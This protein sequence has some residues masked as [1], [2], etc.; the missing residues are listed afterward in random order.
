M[1]RYGRYICGILTTVALLSASIRWSQVAWAAEDSGAVDIRQEESGGNSEAADGQQ[2]S[3]SDNAE[4]ADGQQGE[5]GGIPEDADGQQGDDA[6]IP[7]GAD[8][9]QKDNSGDAD[10][11][12]EDNPDDSGSADGQQED[13]PDDSGSVDG[14]Q[15]GNSRISGDV[16][17]ETAEWIRT[18]GEAL[19][20]IAA[21][22]DIMALVYLSDEYPV[23][24]APSYESE[25]AVTV[26]SGQ[27]VNILDMAVDENREVWHYVRLDYQGRAIYGYVPRTYLACSDERFLEWEEMFG[28]NAA[29]YAID[30]ERAGYA[31]IQQFPQSYQAA[32]RALKE[33]HPNWTFVVMNTKLDWQ[34]TIDAELQGERSLVY[35]TLPE[36]TKNGLYDTGNWYFASRAAVEVYMDPRNSLTENAIFQ[37]EQLTYNENY[38]TQDAVTKFL[39]GTFMTDEG[40]KRPPGASAAYANLF[41]EI[42]RGEGVS[43]FHLAARVLQE[44]GNGTSPLISGTYSGYEGYYN[45][46]NVGATGK[47]NHQVITSGLQY[48]KEH[49]WNSAESALRGGATFISANYI[50]RAQDTLYL[51]KFNVNPPG[52]PNAYAPYTHQYMQNITAPTTEGQSIKRLYEGAGS[53][54]NTFVFK[55][56]VFE[57]MPAQACAAP[58]VSTEVVVALPEGY[59]DSVMWLD[60]VAYQGELRNGSLIVTA[61]DRNARTAVVYKYDASGVP[62][63]MYVWSLN[64]NGTVYTATAE[65]GLEDLLTYHGFSIRVTGNTGIRYKTGISTQLRSQLTKTGVNGYVLKEY[66][67]LVMNNANMSQY[68]MIKGGAKVA[69]GISYGTD[70]NG[71]RTDIVFEIA[72]GRYRFT[73]VLVGLPV[74]QYKTEFAFRGYAVLEKKGEQVI[75]YGPA[76]A[77]SIY[78]L[79]RVLLNNGT[80][81]QGSESYAFLQKLVSDA[82]AQ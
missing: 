13:N 41:W 22:R 58:G 46:F 44:Q 38:H 72:E 20:Q 63:G 30:G 39:R 65:P 4:A 1:K 59:G 48:A 66:G 78:E 26:L 77:R 76:R 40:G 49:G 45:Y 36:W 34:A 18:S 17:E 33:K 14:Q 37:F 42:G 43:P 75:I 69:G 25:A 68:P 28:M 82:D 23:R 74:E 73:S 6:G 9:G 60:G 29:T 70:S 3:S 81:E 16:D 61:P 52:T 32:L 51:Q 27:T 80:Y 5:N 24:T 19:A 53:L 2:G 35:S 79:A 7:E 50:K 56:P 57:N 15:E 55:I 31:D 47:T 67:T 12:Q 64:H 62:T 54:D 21:E 11:Q 8:P 10:G 71:N